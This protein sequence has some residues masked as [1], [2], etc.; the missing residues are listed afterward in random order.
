MH[1]TNICRWLLTTA[2]LTA[3]AACS[4]SMVQGEGTSAAS[5]ADAGPTERTERSDAS[6]ETAT[7]ASHRLYLNFDGAAVAPGRVD[8]A[9]GRSPLAAKSVTLAPFEASRFA[10]L[11]REPLIAKVKELIQGAFAPYDIDVVTERPA[12]PLEYE[13]VVFSNGAI[14]QLSDEYAG[15]SVN[16]VADFD[17]K[18]A[19]ERGV[20]FIFPETLL[21]NI[22]A[23]GVTQD[24][25]T[26]L[27]S[28]AA[29]EVGHLLGLKDTASEQ[30]IMFPYAGTALTFGGEADIEDVT[31]DG[32]VFVACGKAR[33]QDSAAV[34]G[35]ALGMR[36]PR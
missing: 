33:K 31:G 14:E 9:K 12:P 2:L 32:A 21:D 1:S 10:P 29:H 17:C 20:G 24:P 15:F 8:S 28:V 34:V 19:S 18:N 27:A 23:A 5:S 11:S 13:M 30:D 36:A 16:G 25:V 3:G 6:S 26:T 4:T 7:P 35:K 22:A